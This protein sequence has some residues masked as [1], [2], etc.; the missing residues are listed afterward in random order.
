MPGNREKC[1][2]LTKLTFW[3]LTP[4]NEA[5]F[6]ACFFL[7]SYYSIEGLSFDIG[8]CHGAPIS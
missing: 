3:G 1:S 6:H 7:G 2:F 5:R 8:L 4:I